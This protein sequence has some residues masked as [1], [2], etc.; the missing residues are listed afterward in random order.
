MNIE[1]ERVLALAGIIQVAGLV[2]KIARTSRFDQDAF[3]ASIHSIFK[4]NASTVED[5]Y[6]GVEHLQYGLELLSKLFG[7]N[8]KHDDLEIARYTISMVVLER[9]LVKNTT[10]LDRI[11]AGIEKA[12]AQSEHFGSKTHEN[13]IANLADLYLS[14]ISTLSPRIMVNGEHG[15]LE[16]PENANKVRALLL[17]GIRSAVLWRQKGGGRLQLVFGRNKIVQIADKLLAD[18]KVLH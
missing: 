13:I 10:V 18:I 4:I 3:Q 9:K 17:A 5:V 15:Y 14:T 11:S 12:Q 1:S 16:I 2:Q 6:G 8:K 7:K